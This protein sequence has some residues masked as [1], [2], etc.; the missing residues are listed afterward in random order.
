MNNEQLTVNRLQ[1]LLDYDPLTGVFV[2]RTNRGGRCRV[3]QVAGT[4]D[5]DGYLRIMVDGKLYRA[6]RLAWLYVHG[7]FPPDQLDHA[8]RVRSDNRIDNLR[9]ATRQQNAVNSFRAD[10]TS[11]RKGV[12]WSNKC[13]KWLVQIR[14]NGKRHN[15]GHYND[16]EEASACYQNIARI[17]HGEFNG[18]VANVAVQ[19]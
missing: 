18:F 11:G 1:Y 19:P 8:N 10:N 6:H 12:T 7:E 15:L 14:V 4:L 16:I 2:N 3:G 13:E 5:A 9:P 17:L